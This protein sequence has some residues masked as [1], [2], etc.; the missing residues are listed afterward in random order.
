MG[1]FRLRLRYDIFRCF[2]YIQKGFNLNFFDNDISNKKR[3]Q[4][5]EKKVFYD[6][7]LQEMKANSFLLRFCLRHCS[8]VFSLLQISPEFLLGYLTS[9]DPSLNVDGIVQHRL[10]IPGFPDA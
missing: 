1:E 7:N 9:S 4:F 5:T 6:G 10:N 8:F 2:F 3:V